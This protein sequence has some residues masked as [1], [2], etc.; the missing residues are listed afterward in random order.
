MQCQVMIVQ[1]PC[2]VIDSYCFMNIIVLGVVYLIR[3][4]F[5]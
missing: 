1:N 5:C 3:D 2:S 4:S